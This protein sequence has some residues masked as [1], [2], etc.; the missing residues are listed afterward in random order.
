M[1][2]EQKQVSA[3]SVYLAE[4]ESGYADHGRNNCT[5]WLSLDVYLLCSLLNM[6]PKKLIVDGHSKFICSRNVDQIHDGLG[7]HVNVGWSSRKDN[8]ATDASTDAYWC[9]ASVWT[10]QEYVVSFCQSCKQIATELPSGGGRQHKA[11]QTL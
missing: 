9:L 1:V 5:Q 6:W 10:I 11:G 3:D 7:R 2:V 8:I 4:S